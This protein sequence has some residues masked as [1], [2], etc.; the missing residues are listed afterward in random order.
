MN[1][2]QF[3]IALALLAEIQ[4][5]DVGDLRQTIKQAG[6]SQK[7]GADFM[8][9]ESSAH[10]ISGGFGKRLALRPLC[11]FSRSP[12]HTLFPE[13]SAMSSQLPPA[14][15]SSLPSL[16]PVACEDQLNYATN[17]VSSPLRSP[18]K[19]CPESSPPN[20][21][22][23]AEARD[24][25]DAALLFGA[26]GMRKD[27]TDEHKQHAKKKASDALA[28]ALLAEARDSGID[29][30]HSGLQ[31]AK[32][33]AQ[34]ALDF[35]LLTERNLDIDVQTLDELKLHAQDAVQVGLL[36]MQRIEDTPEETLSPRLQASALEA[37]EQLLLMASQALQVRLCGKSLADAGQTARWAVARAL[38]SELR[39][40]GVEVTPQERQWALEQACLALDSVTLA[41]TCLPREGGEFSLLKQ[42]ALNILHLALLGVKI[43]L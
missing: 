32:R 42:R 7:V 34:G 18:I 4:Q 16:V 37:V 14:R 40:S 41:E 8:G 36:A 17:C 21:G 31:K 28:L 22:Q 33:I 2:Q 35:T 12:S 43:S 29:V 1:L 11:A 39:C 24:A 23:P 9:R 26:K 38:D 15:S 27:V 30:T 13:K 19:E 5:V 10:A 20:N 6:A 3:E 25:L